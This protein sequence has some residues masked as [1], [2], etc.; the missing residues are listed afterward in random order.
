[1]DGIGPAE[2]EAAAAALD[3][4]VRRTPMVRLERGAFGQDEAAL[5]LKL[6]CLQITGSFKVRGAFNLLLAARPLPAVG[7]VAASGG[8]HGSAVAYAARQLGVPATIFVPETTPPAKLA[9]LGQF[10]AT[11]R[12]GGQYYAD[13]KDAADAWQAETGALAVPAF[14]DDRVIAGQGTTAREFAADAPFDTLLVAVGGGG[15]IAGA[16]AALGETVRLVGVETEGTR[17]LAHALAAGR[18]VEVMISGLAADALGARKIGVRPFALIRRRG[19]ESVVVEDHAVRA[20]QVALWRTLRTAAEPG[21][22]VALAALLAGAYRPRR[23][24]RVG[25]VVCGANLDPAALA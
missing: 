13:A 22:A 16:A 18:P 14:D 17:S 20:A 10:G 2:V 7:V 11:V 12:V 21:G 25:V 1:M 19:V 6:E 3:G 5:T 8:N 23:G 9:R 15:L 24:E 4:R